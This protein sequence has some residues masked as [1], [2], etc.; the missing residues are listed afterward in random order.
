[1]S[2]AKQIL[3][4]VED[5]GGEEAGS[6]EIDKITVEQARAFASR[7]IDLDRELP[8][9][10]R[11]F[12]L[13]QKLA[14][15]GVTNRADMPV[16]SSKEVKQFQAQLEGGY[17]D[18]VH[19]FSPTTN[20]VSPFPLGL[21]GD[22]AK[23]WMQNGLKKF[24]GS[25]RDDKVGVRIKPVRVSELRP[26]QRQIYFDKAMGKIAKRGVK[27]M[28]AKLMD[29][30]LIASSDLHIIDG[31]HRFLAALLINPSMKLN[32]CLVDLPIHLLYPLSLAYSDAMGKPR[33]A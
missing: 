31:H 10:D 23:Q 3:R 6:L 28:T 1:M 21:S 8:N 22:Q 26:I 32:V 19:P 24:D 33:N 17:I 30:I 14:G 12:L 4:L 5:S 2:K 18:L 11:N 9:F 16:I 25:G 29:A 15:F 13:A 27:G 7:F 20:P